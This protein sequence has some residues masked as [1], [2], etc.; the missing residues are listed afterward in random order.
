MSDKLRSNIPNLLLMVKPKHFGFNSETAHSN[1]FQNNSSIN[2]LK[3]VVDNCFEKVLQVF[4]QNGI[5]YKIFEDQEESS[6]DA[7][8]SNNWISSDPKGRVTL[9]PMFTKSRRNEVRKDIAD[10][11]MEVTNGNE[12]IDLTN[13]AAQQFF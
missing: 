8:F 10:W 3:A 13:Q 4:N 12:L 7:V 11:V 2:N 9:Y 1:H 5:A 6:P